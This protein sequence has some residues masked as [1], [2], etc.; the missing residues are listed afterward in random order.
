MFGHRDDVITQ[1]QKADASVPL[2]DS[3]ISALTGPSDPTP[4]TDSQ[5]AVVSAPTFND[6]ASD[7]T[8]PEPEMLAP[9]PVVQDFMFSP[10]NRT[11]QPSASNADPD[12]LARAHADAVSLPPSPSPVTP[13]VPAVDEVV[14][15]NDQEDA[16]ET[17]DPS[18]PVIKPQSHT[19]KPAAS[20]DKLV[21]IKQEAL[22]SLSPL[23]SQLDLDPEEKFKTLMMLIQA[24]D[25]QSLVGTAYDVAKQIPDEKARAQALLDIVN[26]INYFTQKKEK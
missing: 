18:L 23:V 8:L 19:I 21:S 2:P 5:A 17:P 4:P 25:D 1:D 20:T 3:T 6:P 16:P 24:S 9:K 7:D 15:V 12:S 11:V 14:K 26:E 22:Q 10:G 13:E